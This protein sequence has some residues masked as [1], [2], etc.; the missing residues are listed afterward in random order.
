[1]PLVKIAA[2][3]AFG[4]AGHTYTFFFTGALWL[5]ALLYA[6]GPKTIAAMNAAVAHFFMVS[7]LQDRASSRVV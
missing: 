7:L 1:V 3:A 2:V 5:A 6:A 4:A